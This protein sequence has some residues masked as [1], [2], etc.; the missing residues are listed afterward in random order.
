MDIIMRKRYRLGIKRLGIVGIMAAVLPMTAC[1]VSG[2][3]LTE[4]QNAQVVEYAVGLMLKYDANY[5][6]RLAEEEGNEEEPAEETVKPAEP[7]KENAPA[8]ESGSTKP[9]EEE[10]VQEEEIEDRSIEEFCGIEGAVISYTGYEVKDVYPET[11]G[12]D[13]VF[14]MN[15]SEGCKLIILNFDVQNIGSQD[16]KMD[17]LSEETKFK[18]SLNDASPK[19]A[20]TTMLEN[21]LASYVGTIPAGASENLILVCEVPDEKAESIQTITLLMRNSLEEGRLTLN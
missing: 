16:L 9:L 20:L 14:A 8:E 6:S 11:S 2:P 12:E 13:L 18:I 17:M 21:D 3:E 10:S 15:A 1:G 7:P 5:H 19:Y 4:E